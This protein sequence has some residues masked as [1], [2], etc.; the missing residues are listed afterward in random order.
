MGHDT[1]LLLHVYDTYPGT[2]FSIARG[3]C[4]INH[5]WTKHSRTEFEDTLSQHL[6]Y[7]R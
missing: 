6:V 3:L 7:L 4:I 2:L 5:N 1:S